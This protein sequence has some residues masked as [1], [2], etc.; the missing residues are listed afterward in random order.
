MAIIS[1][2]VMIPLVAVWIYEVARIIIY[3]IHYED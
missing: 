3:G 2:V 1:A